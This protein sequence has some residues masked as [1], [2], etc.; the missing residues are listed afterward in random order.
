M[1]PPRVVKEEQRK[2]NTRIENIIAK[3]W[4]FSARCATEL[5]RVP[6]ANFQIF[7]HAHRLK[8]ILSS[9]HIHFINCTIVRR[10]PYG[11]FGGGN[12]QFKMYTNV[13][14]QLVFLWRKR[15]HEPARVRRD[16][17]RVLEVNK[18]PLAPFAHTTI[19]MLQHPQNK[20]T[21]KH[22]VSVFIATRFTTF[23]LFLLFAPVGLHAL[24]ILHQ[25]FIVLSIFLRQIIFASIRIMPAPASTPHW[26][27]AQSLALLAIR[28]YR[29]YGI[30][31]VGCWLC[32]L[33]VFC[34]LSFPFANSSKW[35]SIF[36]ANKWQRISRR[37]S[38]T[39]TPHI[40]FTVYPYF[41]GWQPLQTF[42]QCVCCRATNIG[43]KRNENN[44]SLDIVQEYVV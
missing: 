8:H 20:Q 5:A 30:G 4:R 42:S 40:S 31:I 39:H 17:F 24:R 41:S 6:P 26:A 44:N 12:V 37:S 19:E 32:V 22:I 23:S 25:P 28:E 13:Y 10:G 18:K 16:F 29:N 33:F 35:K 34:F 1:W 14:M 27:N 15:R 9:Q 7:A 43:A 11:L 36:I 3:I 21:Q 38:N 2:E